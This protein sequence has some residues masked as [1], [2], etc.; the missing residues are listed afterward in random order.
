MD[1]PRNRG[2]L[3][4][5]GGILGAVIGTGNSDNFS[6]ASGQP[7]GHRSSQGSTKQ[8]KGLT[9]PSAKRAEKARRRLTR[10]AR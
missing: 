7:H 5:L 2:L 4:A 3:L 1:R 9:G 6:I 8:R 10:R